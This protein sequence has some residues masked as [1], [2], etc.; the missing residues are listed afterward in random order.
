M[1]TFDICVSFCFDNEKFCL[2][3][4]SEGVDTG[5]QFGSGEDSIIDRGISVAKNDE[6]G[7]GAGYCTVD[8]QMA[9][10][11]DYIIGGV[12][13][14]GDLTGVDVDWFLVVAL[15]GENDRTALL[16]AAELTA[17]QGQ[18]G[19]PTGMDRGVEEPCIGVSKDG[20]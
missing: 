1:L 8:C 7:V 14:L 20:P 9:V 13:R 4:R 5:C 17:V 15:P 3:N 16:E 6:P 18:R 2:K 10:A 12:G 11:G 19:G